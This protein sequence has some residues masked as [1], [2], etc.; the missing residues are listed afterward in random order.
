[1]RPVTQPGKLQPELD[2]VAAGGVV[3]IRDNGRYA[4]PWTLKAEAGGHV[5]FR[6]ANGAFPALVGP[7]PFVIDAEADS[8]ITLNGLLIVG[9]LLT[10]TGQPRSVRL[11]HCTLAPGSV[12]DEA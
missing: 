9:G 1:V 11:T 5:E 7:G 8:E 4:D 12:R 10:I 2:A 6:G 3:E